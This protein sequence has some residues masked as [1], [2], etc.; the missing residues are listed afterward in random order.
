MN[1]V[2]NLYTRNPLTEVNSPLKEDRSTLAGAN[3]EVLI[4]LSNLN[5]NLSKSFTKA[6]D[7]FIGTSLSTPNL[8]DVLKQSAEDRHLNK[9][10]LQERDF[11]N[12]SPYLKNFTGD[13]FKIVHDQRTKARETT[14]TIAYNSA[15]D[16]KA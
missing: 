10:Y 2:R 16:K 7:K 4:D 13:P 8:S 9:K 11:S 5:Q 15:K 1:D 14:R 6:D 12:Q 3:R